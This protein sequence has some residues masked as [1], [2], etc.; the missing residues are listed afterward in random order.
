MSTILIITPSSCIGGAERQIAHITQGLSSE[1][2]YL[3]TLKGNGALFK[4]GKFDRWH[5][6]IVPPVWIK[7]CDVVL[8]FL[9]W[10]HRLARIWVGNKP[11]IASIRNSD[12][13]K[14]KWQIF[15]DK[16]VLKRS[17]YVVVNHPEIVKLINTREN[18]SKSKLKYIPNIIALP[19][20][21][22]K[23]K[24]DL[25]LSFDIDSNLPWLLMVG[26]TQ[27]QKNQEYISSVLPILRKNGFKFKLI[28]IGFDKDKKHILGSLNNDPEV[29]FLPP[30]SPWEFYLA[31]DVLLHPSLWEG[32]PNVVFEAGLSDLPVIVSDKIGIDHLGFYPDGIL[33]IG[34]GSQKIWAQKIVEFC[35]HPPKPLVEDFRN[36]V[37][38]T[39]SKQNVLPQWKS[40]FESALEK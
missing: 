31:A 17:K 35:N 15:W 25:G 24:K 1:N 39:Y 19:K 8:S 18:V 30:G 7:K 4:E 29:A 14:K 32:F 38:Q 22:E 23:H 6:G 13:E 3:W 37:E 28:I 40:I 36:F 34:Q 21:R 16:Q 20:G 33:P 2:F 11:W 5:Q 27:K 10:G 9:S 12:P 26:H